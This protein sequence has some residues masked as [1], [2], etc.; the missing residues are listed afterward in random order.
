MRI[1]KNPNISHAAIVE[2]NDSRIYLWERADINYY[3]EVLGYEIVG[4]EDVDTT[5]KGMDVPI[6]IKSNR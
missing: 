1:S 6:I 5:Q 4:Y 3:T 2:K